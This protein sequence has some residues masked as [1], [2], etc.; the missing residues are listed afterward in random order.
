MAHP[1]VISKH[2]QMQ[3]DTGLYKKIGNVYSPEDIAKWI[4]DRKRL[5]PTKEHVAQRQAEQE[6]KLKRGERLGEI[7]N[8]F[9]R[10]S[11]SFNSGGRRGTGGGFGRRGRGRG[12]GH[13]YRSFPCA[14]SN[15]GAMD[16]TRKRLQ[17][18]IAHEVEDN[19][20]RK[21]PPFPGTAAFSDVMVAASIGEGGSDEDHGQ[22]SDSEWEAAGSVAPSNIH[23]PVVS[24]ALSSLM[25][26]YASESEGEEGKVS[27]TCVLSHTRMEEAVP[28]DS[29][30]VNNVDVE[31]SRT[32]ITTFHKQH[33]HSSKCS[34]SDSGPD[35]APILRE[36]RSNTF[37]TCV[38]SHEHRGTAENTRRRR[39][40][41]KHSSCKKVN[42]PA[43]EKRDNMNNERNSINKLLHVRQRKLTLLEKLLSREIRHERNMVLQ[44]VRYAIQNN[45]FTGNAGV[46]TEKVTH[47][48]N[49]VLQC[50]H[51]VVGTDF[52]GVL[53]HAHSDDT[54][55]SKEGGGESDNYKVV[56][57][58]VNEINNK[59]Y[60]VESDLGSVSDTDAVSR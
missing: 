11:V 38:E 5:Y 1:K 2:V 7:K 55:G 18:E 56:C 26:L 48:L 50:V 29:S 10:N 30:G 42:S 17:L 49:A 34:G 24:K 54:V 25:G 60:V 43:T 3:H 9:G 35:E 20:C 8:R 37:L 45:F 22:F 52:L 15:S 14:N 4:A 33:E 58:S 51:Y 46:E 41:H 27:P 39:R 36:S 16:K 31:G 6:E 40:H 19:V 12:R 44:C 53:L 47:S 57:N 32:I 13:P 28:C 21:L 23:V 59:M